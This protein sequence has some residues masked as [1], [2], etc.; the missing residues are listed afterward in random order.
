MQPN[1]DVI[2]LCERSEYLDPIAQDAQRLEDSLRDVSKLADEVSYQVR[3]LDSLRVRR[4]IFDVST[5]MVVFFSHG[6]ERIEI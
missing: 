2:L 5:P 1:K 6:M 4:H 3:Q